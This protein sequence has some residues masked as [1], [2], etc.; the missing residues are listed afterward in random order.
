MLYL[1]LVLVVFESVRLTFRYVFYILTNF[2]IL[3]RDWSSGNVTNLVSRIW[4]DIFTVVN[5]VIIDFRRSPYDMEAVS[6]T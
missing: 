6:Q 3:K 4:V 2:K 5:N 1:V